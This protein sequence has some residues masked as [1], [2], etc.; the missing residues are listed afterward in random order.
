MA[1]VTGAAQIVFVEKGA[2]VAVVLRDVDLSAHDV[3][4]VGRG[5]EAAAN[6]SNHAQRIASQYESHC[7]RSP[8]CFVIEP[9]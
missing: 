3:V 2:A 6:H 7:A 5:R 1:S 8:C 4:N 9:L